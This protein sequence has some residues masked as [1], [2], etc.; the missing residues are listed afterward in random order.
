MDKLRRYYY[1][2]ELGYEQQIGARLR[3]FWRRFSEDNQKENQKDG[4]KDGE[5]RT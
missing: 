5:K 4:P 1:P 3:R 2:G